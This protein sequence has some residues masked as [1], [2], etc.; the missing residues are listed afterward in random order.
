MKPVVHMRRTFVHVLDSSFITK[1]IT[2]QPLY[3]TA[4]GVFDPF[5]VSLIKFEHGFEEKIEE[6]LAM[7][8]YM[9]TKFVGPDCYLYPTND[10]GRIFKIDSKLSF[11]LTR[12]QPCVLACVNEVIKSHHIKQQQIIQAGIEATLCELETA[13]CKQKY[14][15]DD[16][17]SLAD[18]SAI[19]TVTMLELVNFDLSKFPAILAWI[20]LIKSLPF[21]RVSNF[22]FEEYKKEAKTQLSK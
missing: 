12:L 3:P 21:Y 15:A 9:C 4:D 20:K 13:V 2:V 8:R 19:T 7:M 1:Y 16:K 11:D 14:V 22:N 17:L 6:T 18:I 5:W 10:P